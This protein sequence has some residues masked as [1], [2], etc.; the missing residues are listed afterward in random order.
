[1]TR[2]EIRQVVLQSLKGVAP[3]LDAAT[4]SPSQELRDQLEIDSFDFLNFIIALDKKLSL[5]IPESDYR[6]LGTLND[7]IE[8]LAARL[9]QPAIEKGA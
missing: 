8:Y 9:Q 1:V 4:L 3:E 5:P 7:C 2:N 6:R